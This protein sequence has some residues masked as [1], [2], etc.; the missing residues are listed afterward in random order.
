M[1]WEPYQALYLHVPF[2]KR[3]C[4]YCDFSTCAVAPDSPRIGEYVENMVAA[5]RKASRADELGAIETVYFGGGTPTFLGNKHLSNL[6]YTLSLSMHLTPEVECTVEANPDSLTLPMVKD[7]YALGATRLSLGVQSFED[8]LLSF[9]GRVHSSDQAKRAIETA[10]TRFDNVSIDLMCGLPGQTEEGF[11]ADVA[12]A[13]SLGVK[14]VSIYP[15]M[16]EEGTPLYGRVERG[17]VGV[18]ED[19]GA[20]LM[21]V[22]SEV[23]ADAGMHRYEVASYAFEGFESRHNT[24]YWTGKPYLGLGPGAVSMR[25]NALERQR[26][27]DGEVVEALDPFEMA[28]EDLMLGMRMSRGVTDAFLEERSILLPEAPDAFAELQ[29]EGL[30]SHREGAWVPTERG[31]LFGNRLYG[32]LYELAP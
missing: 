26:V 7:L 17:E 8:D 21:Q 28:T 2:C 31:W 25:Q 1:E 11:R 9:L 32:K 20:D 30:V 27:K 24:A 12:C 4:A 19:L 16:V 10:Q 15:L 18:D 13:L 6:L 3:R 23:L 29:D 14:H 5:I 22:A